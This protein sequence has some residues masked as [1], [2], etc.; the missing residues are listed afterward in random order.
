MAEGRIIILDN[1]GDNNYRQSLREYL[2]SPIKVDM[3]RLLLDN[4]SQ[5]NNILKIRNSKSVGTQSN[6]D[7]S[8]TQYINAMNKTNLIMDIPLDPPMIIDGQTSF[9]IVLEPTTEIN[10]MFYFDQADRENLLQ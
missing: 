4:V 2:T 5:I 7:I 1:A 6:R 10:I 9:Q 3:M 8:L